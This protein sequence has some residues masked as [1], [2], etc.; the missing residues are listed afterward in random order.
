MARRAIGS[1]LR[2]AGAGTLLVFALFAMTGI[3]GASSGET[4]YDPA[5]ARAVLAQ[6]AAP[7]ALSV[8]FIGNSHIFHNDV[9]G[10]MA[11][12]ATSAGVPPPRVAQIV[13]GGAALAEAAQL[14]EVRAL[15]GDPAWDVV[16]LQERAL[17]PLFPKER[18][19][20]EAAI[21]LLAGQAR[22][23][24]ARV[25]IYGVWPRAP[26]NELYRLGPSRWF[27][28]PSDP[29]EM[30]AMLKAEL[31][32]IAEDAGADLVHVGDDWLRAAAVLPPGTLYWP[33]GYHSSLAGGYLAAA[34]LAAALTGVSPEAMRH[35]PEGLDPA[36]AGKISEA[37]AAR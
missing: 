14:P 30:N 7:G 5:A 36:I 29:E 33:D 27:M 4:F 37:L 28:G 31:S 19:L 18:T 13:E 9:A 20:S 23:A 26:G 24:G 8:L 21:A 10:Q 2:G 35:V 11:V 34:R 16:V 1:F 32:R 3:R 12:L 25:V 17:E 15:A 22:R 6:P